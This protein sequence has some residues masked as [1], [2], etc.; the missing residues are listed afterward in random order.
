MF[1]GGGVQFEIL[2][3]PGIDV[4]SGFRKNAQ[5]GVQI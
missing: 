1:K 2:H 3:N 4:Y 5:E